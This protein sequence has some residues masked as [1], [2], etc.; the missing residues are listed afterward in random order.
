MSTLK[1]LVPA[2]ALM[3]TLWSSNV[4][5]A[6]SAE[7]HLEKIQGLV[8]MM[9]GEIEDRGIV[10]AGYEEEIVFRLTRMQNFSDSALFWMDFAP[11]Y[12]EMLVEFIRDDAKLL[13]STAFD[14][15]YANPADRGVALRIWFLSQDAMLV[16]HEIIYK[17]LL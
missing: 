12:S 5:Q 15:Y 7:G 14:L 9:E 2:L 6:Q 8:H 4:A 13:R 1:T 16:A 10:T 3:T 11:D 17:D